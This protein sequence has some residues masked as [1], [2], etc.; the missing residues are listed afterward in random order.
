[1]TE[2]HET[3]H[4]EHTSAQLSSLDEQEEHRNKDENVN[5]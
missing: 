1:M 3:A 4:F 5:R 2:F